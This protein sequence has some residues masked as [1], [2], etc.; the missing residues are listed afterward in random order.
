MTFERSRQTRNRNRALAYPLQNRPACGIAQRVENAINTCP[1]I[2]HSSAFPLLRGPRK[3]DFGLRGINREL[4]HASSFDSLSNSSRHPSLRIAGPS[5]PSKNAACSVKIE[6]GA[7]FLCASQPQFAS[8]G[9]RS[10]ESP[11]AKSHGVGKHNPRV[12]HDV[13]IRRIVRAYN[14][15]VRTAFD[16]KTRPLPSAHAKVHFEFESSPSIFLSLNQRR[17]LTGSAKAANTRCGVAG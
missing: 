13:L 4:R 1:Q 3:P 2:T 8:A 9:Q 6:M 12:G 10:R 16:L 17:F 14:A 15:A 5:A 7:R 11:I